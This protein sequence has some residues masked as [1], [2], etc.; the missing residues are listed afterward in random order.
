VSTLTDFRLA[1]GLSCADM[2]TSVLVET[3]VLQSVV[4]SKKKISGGR[5]VTVLIRLVVLRLEPHTHTHMIQDNTDTK[6]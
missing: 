6:G 1:S 5:F 3:S 2:S 4:C